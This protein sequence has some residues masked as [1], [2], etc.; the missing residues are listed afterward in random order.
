[1]SA[2]SAL[3]IELNQYHAVRSAEPCECGTYRY[4]VR[5][6][7]GATLLMCGSLAT[8]GEWA[9]KLN[10]RFGIDQIGAIR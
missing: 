6:P 1:M 10:E 7:G 8:A 4:E 3:D 2:M 5:K 9:D